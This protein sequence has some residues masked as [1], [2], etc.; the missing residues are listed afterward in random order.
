MMLRASD[1]RA[2]AELVRNTC[3]R[4]TG[5][6]LHDRQARGAMQ[7]KAQQASQAS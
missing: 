4:T 7:W 1:Q 5:A 2:Y 6:C 3:A